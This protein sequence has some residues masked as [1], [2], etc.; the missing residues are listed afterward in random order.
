[1]AIRISVKNK[2]YDWAIKRSQVDEVSLHRSFPKL[3][4]WKEGKSKPTLKQLEKFAKRIYLSVGTLLMPEPLEESLPLSD[5]RTVDSKAIEIPSAN[6]L[7]TLHMCRERQSWY[8]DFA[9]A[10]NL[11]QASFVGSF[12][13][14]NNIVE[15]AK[16]IREA[17]GFDFN[18]SLG[19]GKALTEFKDKIQ[20][21]GILVMISGVVGNNTH[22]PLEVKEFRGF[23][24][25]DTQAP[26][27]FINSNDSK[28]AQMFSLAHEV[29]HLWL[30][31]S[32][33]SNGYSMKST[34]YEE[35][36]WCNKVAAEFLVPLE[37]FRSELR[38]A[39]SVNQ[40]L[41]RLS[42]R[43]KVSTLVILIRLLD[44]G[45]INQQGFEKMWSSETER[46]KNVTKEN[47]P[48]GNFYNTADYRLSQNFIRSLMVYTLEG[49][50]LYRDAFRLLG[51]KKMATF[52]RMGNK[53]GIEM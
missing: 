48:G 26:L 12:T 35:E 29:A 47:G 44:A 10:E 30:G 33:L 2:M 5:F 18:S 11:P 28:H 45:K 53:I 40:T 20:N 9:M 49:H 15:S 19:L 31:N 22:R 42:K 38:Q 32:A 52:H 13:T 46:L 36:A 51:I 24:L 23:T 6:L 43:F 17:I 16:T 8:R 50:T 27:I 39:E 14:K 7:D 3:K 1:M 21:L 34:K 41:E 4:E 37:I 25:S